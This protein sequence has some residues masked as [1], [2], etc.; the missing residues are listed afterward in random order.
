MCVMRDRVIS[1]LSRR[2]FIA[3]A[4]AASAPR[5]LEAQPAMKVAVIGFVSERALPSLYIDALRNGL[6]TRGWV[7][8]A[9][10]R[11]EP[12]SADGDLD[13]LPGLVTE[14]VGRGVSL[15]VTGIGSPV[16]LAAKKATAVIPIVFVTGGDPVDFGIVS[17]AAKP[18]GNITG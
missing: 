11:I 10:F 14:L 3:G 1:R 17:N 8:G 16:A 15:I 5:R 2:A 18:G 9:Q 7:E 12:R 13:R 6:A 4:L